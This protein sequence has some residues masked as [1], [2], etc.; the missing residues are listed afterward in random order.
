MS[1]GKSICTVLKT[2]RKQVADANGITYEPHECHYQGECRGTYLACE[3]EV[4]YLEQ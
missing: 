4:R 1:N 2:I 3:A